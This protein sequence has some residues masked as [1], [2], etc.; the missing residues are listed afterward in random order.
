M[1]NLL[2]L[3][4]IFFKCV[5]LFSCVIAS[6]IITSCASKTSLK[7]VNKETLAVAHRGA[8]KAK[9][10]PGNSIAAFREAI[11]LKCA[12]S[13]FDVNM[14][15]DDSLVITHGP[16]YHTMPIE[17]TLYTDLIKVNLPNGEKLPTLR[18]FIIA[19]MRNN[20]TTRFFCEI[21]SSSQGQERGLYIADKV[22]R[23]FT[24]LGAQHMVTFIS[25]DY[26]I[27][28]S[29][30][31]KDSFIDTQYLNNNK[32][33]EDLHRDG[34]NGANYRFPYWQKN[35][36]LVAAAQEK[37]IATNSGTVND[38][39]VID[40]LLSQ[41]FDYISSDEPLEV[42]KRSTNKKLKLFDF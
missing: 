26:T 2:F 3:K 36:E 5:F 34:I 6:L 38:T 19:G 25:F 8:W 10:L 32:T 42:I 31:Q 27:L 24:D 13:E 28:K 15:A 33:L 35:P 16:S 30:V 37:G 11:R 17:K 23:T 7:K 40:W 22:Y 18:E 9:G 4:A 41:N 12:G 14:T 29:L 1:K 20:T 21:K 39:L